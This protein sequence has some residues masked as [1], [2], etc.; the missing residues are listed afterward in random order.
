MEVSVTFDTNNEKDLESIKRMSEIFI[1]FLPT[2]E[3]KE[4]EK[5]LYPKIYGK[6]KETVLLAI[7]K[8]D[9]VRVSDL[10]TLT[11]LSMDTI[12]QY[13]SKLV[14]EKKVTKSNTTPRVYYKI[15]ENSDLEKLFPK[16]TK[17]S[18]LG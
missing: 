3:K 8:N 10:R 15:G 18:K 1:D 5:V 16:G 12:N 6:G 4:T 13:L 2:E 11:G 7:N 9:G 14:R 17:V